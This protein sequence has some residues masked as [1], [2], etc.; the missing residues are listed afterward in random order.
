MLNKN[1]ILIVLLIIFCSRNGFSAVSDTVDVNDFQQIVTTSASYLDSGELERAKHLIDYGLENSTDEKIITYLNYYLGGY[2]F[3]HQRYDSA[4]QL[5]FQILPEFEKFQD[6][7]KIAKTLRYI[8]VVYGKKEDLVN[9][10]EFFLRES[11]FLHNFDSLSLS[12]KK[13]Q[14][15]LEIELMSTYRASSDY[16]EIINCASEVIELAEALNDSSYIGIVYNNIG[17]AYEQLEDYDKAMFYYRKAFDVFTATN[18]VGNNI[19]VS[20]NFGSIYENQFLKLD[21]ALM[22]YQ[23]ALRVSESERVYMWIVPS[24]LCIASVYEKQNKLNEAE[25]LLLEIIEVCEE[26]K[27]NDVLLTAIDRIARVYYNQHKYKTAYH[28][29]KKYQYYND[30]IYSDSRQ[31]QLA[32]LRTKYHLARKENEISKLRADKLNQ[33]IKLFKAERQ[34]QVFIFV[35]I[36]LLIIVLSFLFVNR[37]KQ[38]TNSALIE[39]NNKIKLIN[40]KLIKSKQDLETANNAK[41]KL[42]SLIAHDLRSPFNTILGFSSLL[43]EQYVDLSD[44]ERI[45][46]VGYLNDSTSQANALLENLLEWSRTQTKGIVF[47][48]SNIFLKEMIDKVI[49]LQSANAIEKGI[50]VRNEV[51]NVKFWG[52]EHMLAT[53]FRN[54]INNGIKFTSEGVISISSEIK[55]KL[56]IVRIED[57]GVGMPPEKMDKLFDIS[58]DNTTRGTNNEKGTGLGLIVCKEFINYHK[59]NIRVKS[60]VGVGT[61][62]CVELPIKETGSES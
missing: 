35:L 39:K 31:V 60:K 23:N 27:D 4:Q 59:G 62:F 9:Q 61:C 36:F 46:Y 15:A 14:V 10:L 26:Y 13:E 29:A 1:L 50:D 18:N 21:S 34:K 8:G 57:S 42:F 45:N 32:E 30:S 54:I 55:D 51:Q 2:Y 22:F 40:E 33:E 28:Y 3:L 5:F 49:D 58:S 6:T 24:K 19:C 41:N 25:A 16:N 38:R 52:D 56:L 48:P 43:I 17:D 20:L 47:N 11:A 53:V 37:S 12:L 7:L 44:Q